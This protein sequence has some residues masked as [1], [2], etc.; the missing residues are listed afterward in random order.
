MTRVEQTLGHEK[1]SEWKD[2]LNSLHVDV[3]ELSQ[4]DAQ[5][6]RLRKTSRDGEEVIISLERDAFLRDGD[7][8]L[9]DERRAIVCRINL[10]DVMVVHLEPGGDP[11]T[12]MERCVRL[13]HAL[14]NQHWPAVVSNGCVY[15]PLS[16]DRTVM[17]SVMRTHC[18]DGVRYDF[19]PGSDILSLLSPA[20]A[21]RLFGGAEQPL[22][23]HHHHDHHDHHDHGDT[24]CWN[25]HTHS[26][27]SGD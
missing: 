22:Q 9:C 16:V 10:C 5:K 12:F 7:V 1:A 13:G 23:Q 8:L 6:T 17:D 11:V 24:A 27:C 19:I 3:L 15:V 21:R 20:Q 4:W 26:H 18:F 25:P 14:G 2:R